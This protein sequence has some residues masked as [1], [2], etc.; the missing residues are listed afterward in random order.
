MPFRPL[1]PTP[2][3]DLSSTCLLKKHY[4]IVFYLEIHAQSGTKQ[5]NKNASY[6]VFDLYEIK[7]ATI[8]TEKSQITEG[9]KWESSHVV[10]G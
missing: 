8:I 1:S 4:P 9:T 2:K 7:F 6:V 3:H 5:H 10:S